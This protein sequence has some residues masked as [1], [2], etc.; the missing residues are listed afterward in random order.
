MIC[1]SRNFEGMFAAELVRSEQTYLLQHNRSGFPG[2]PPIRPEQQVISAE[3]R[4]SYMYMYM[5]TQH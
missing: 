3:K 2:I 5:T 1:Y 4:Y